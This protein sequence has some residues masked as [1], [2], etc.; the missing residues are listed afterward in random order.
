MEFSH[1]DL[2]DIHEAIGQCLLGPVQESWALAI[3]HWFAELLRPP[4]VSDNQDRWSR[5][6]LKLALL[7]SVR[8]G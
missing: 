4:T 5:I 3:C 1:V 8:L 2:R 6:R 7:L